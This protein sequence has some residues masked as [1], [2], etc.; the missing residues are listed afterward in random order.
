[1]SWDENSNLCWDNRDLLAIAQKEAISVDDSIFL[2]THQP[3]S[4]VRKA[5]EELEG[6]VVNEEHLISEFYA[7]ENPEGLIAVPI[8]GAPGSG[9]SHLVRLLKIRKPDD[10]SLHVVWIPKRATT[11][12]SVINTVLDELDEKQFADVRNSL[13]ISSDQVLDSESGGSRLIDAL[14]QRI[15]DQRKVNLLADRARLTPQEMIEFELYDRIPDLMRDVNFRDVLMNSGVPQRLAKLEIDGRQGNDGLDEMAGQFSEGDIPYDSVED[16]NDLALKARNSWT[17]ITGHNLR[18]ETAEILNRH[19]EEAIRDVFLGSGIPL[20]EVMAQLR[21]RLLAEGKELVL[22]I[23]DMTVLHGIQRQLLDALIAPAFDEGVLRFA[24]IRVAFAFTDG[25]LKELQTLARRSHVYSLELPY[26]GSGEFSR[27]NA[28]SFVARYL[29]AIR[30]G[31]EEIRDWALA[32]QESIPNACES[33]SAREVCLDNEIGFGQIDNI[34]LYPLTVASVDRMLDSIDR[35]QFN[36][37]KVVERI[38][39]GTIK[40]AGTELPLKGFPSEFA[41]AFDTRELSPISAGVQGIIQS[42][43]ESSVDRYSRAYRFWSTN[44]AEF[45]P[46][47]DELT[48]RFNL[49]NPQAESPIPPKPPEP[50]VGPVDTPIDPWTEY[51]SSFDSWTDGITKVA[52]EDRNR[53]LRSMIYQMVAENLGS[54]YGLNIQSPLFSGKDGTFLKDDSIAIENLTGGGGID[55]TNAFKLNIEISVDNAVAIQSLLRGW[56]Q[57]W[58]SDS[59]YFV[60]DDVSTVRN[61]IDKLSQRVVDEFQNRFQPTM[62]HKDASTLL[63]SLAILGSESAI[64]STRSKLCDAIG[65]AVSF[66]SSDISSPD[67]WNKLHELTVDAISSS[68]PVVAAAFGTAKSTGGT[69]LSIDPRFSVILETPNW[70]TETDAIGLTPRQESIREKFILVRDQALGSLQHVEDRILDLV[71]NSQP[72][73]LADSLTAAIDDAANVLLGRGMDAQGRNR[74]VSDVVQ[75]RNILEWPQVPDFVKNDPFSLQTLSFLAT[76]PLDRFREVAQLL[77][78]LDASLSAW[79]ELMSSNPASNSDPGLTPDVFRQKL[80]QIVETTRII[81]ELS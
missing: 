6:V 10:P 39:V 20:N 79:D 24:K 29:N 63:G 81:E 70:L 74:A 34:G 46:L 66:S 43:D 17:F 14:A 44:L 60:G 47:G 35:N 22:L 13:R 40:S 3:L 8:T 31:V 68:G 19:M 77:E 48:R 1:M 59:A 58:K 33:C 30:L 38:F 23:E 2:A 57:E 54:V 55:R 64:V 69:T 18:E 27:E 61:W 21:L 4:L 41:L 36:P 75:L 56:R 26:K 65:A 62:L 80:I 42:L 67:D 45:I 9:K 11:L 16:V 5:F 12:R 51:I 28:H 49:L 71:G 53:T 7:T 73:T 78:R 72:A 37:A 50:K 52:H 32:P 76:F 25:R 15:D